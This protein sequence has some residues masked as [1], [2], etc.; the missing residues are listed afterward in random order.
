MDSVS[1]DDRE[2]KLNNNTSDN[3]E[4]VNLTYRN[5]ESKSAFVSNNIIG[6][7]DFKKDDMDDISNRL[8]SVNIKD[9]GPQPNEFNS[10]SDRFEVILWPQVWDLLVNGIFILKILLG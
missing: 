4:I 3:S 8:A 6:P 10:V 2:F 7:N 9:R 5:S 1:L